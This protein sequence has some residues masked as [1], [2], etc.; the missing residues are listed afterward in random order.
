M[1]T[2]GQMIEQRTEGR[3][4]QTRGGQE[5]SRDVGMGYRQGQG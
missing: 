5:L 3:V 2:E 1:Q 4:V